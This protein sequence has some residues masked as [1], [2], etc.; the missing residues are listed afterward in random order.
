MALRLN[1]LVA[2]DFDDVSLSARKGLL[3]IR[4]G[5]GDLYREVPLNPS[6]RHALTAWLRERAAV[7]GSRPSLPVPRADG[8]R[9][10]RSISSCVASPPEQN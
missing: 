8:C 7:D 4:S 2:L 6:C 5:K 3:V 10:E 1:E 9:P